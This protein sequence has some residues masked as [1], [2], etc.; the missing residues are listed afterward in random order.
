[1]LA[2]IAGVAGL[3]DR[4][5][6]KGGT[7]LKKAYFK[8][9]R[10]SEDLDYSTLTPEPLPDVNVLMR[11]AVLLA[12]ELLQERGA[13]RIGFERLILRD[14]HPGDQAAFTIR[15]QFPYQRSPLCRLKVEI[16]ADE[17]VLLAPER[18]KILHDFDETFST[19]VSVY[20]LAE[21]VAEKLRALLQCRDRLHARGWGAVRVCRDY[22]DLWRILGT[23]DFTNEN[24]PGLTAQKCEHRGIVLQSPDSFFAPELVAVAEAE[25]K[26]QLKPFVINCPKVEAVLQDLESFVAKVLT[27]SSD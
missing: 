21:I 2:G 6:L 8:E 1:L 19:R 15:V 9:Y 22:Y 23:Q 27:T 3:A 26:K 13:F 16:T 10:F 12:T 7:A 5:V 17:P 20:P 18:R 24:I 25:W 14:P 11:N 4:V